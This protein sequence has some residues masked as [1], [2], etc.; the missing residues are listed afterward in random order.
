M[1]ALFVLRH[2]S[3]TWNEAERYQGRLESPLSP[4]GFMQSRL[5]ARTFAGTDLDAV[6][7]SPLQ[8]ALLL[9]RDVA[10]AAD[11]PLFTDQRLTEMGQAPFEG[12]Y[13]WE[14]EHEFPNLYREWRSRPDRVLYPGFEPV[15]SVQ[16]RAL[17]VM[18]DLFRRC[19]EGNVVVVT[20]S[21]V[22]QVLVAASLGLDLQFIHRVRVLNAGITTIYGA[23]PPGS[24]LSL[25][26]MDA[27]YHSPVATSDALGDRT[28]TERR[29]AS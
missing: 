14:I 17:S 29:R 1:T 8:R 28:T 18:A 6:Y 24:L 7:S 12:L 11:A 15:K 21:V 3:T 2:P 16:Q 19:P 25:N 9:A 27:L 4:T 13:L 10:Q 20:H 23:E 5:V 22:V 26:V